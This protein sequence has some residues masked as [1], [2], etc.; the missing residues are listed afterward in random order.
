MLTECT[1]SHIRPGRLPPPSSL[2]LLSFSRQVACGMEY[3]ANKSFV[4]RDLAARNILLN[5]LHQCKVSVTPKSIYHQVY[6]VLLCVQGASI[7]SSLSLCSCRL[8]ILVWQETWRTQ[9]TILCPEKD[10]CHSSGLHQRCII[11]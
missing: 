11:P 2:R 3:L 5:E 6:I 7:Y 1:I 9:S 10:Q 4:H 8:E